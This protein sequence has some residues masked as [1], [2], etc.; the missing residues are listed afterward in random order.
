MNWKIVEQKIKELDSETN[1]SLTRVHLD[2][3]LRKPISDI[4]NDAFI[5][6]DLS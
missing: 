3:V 1:N 4:N 2:I 6:I 5:K